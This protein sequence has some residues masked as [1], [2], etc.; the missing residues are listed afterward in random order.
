[1]VGHEGTSGTP[2]LYNGRDGVMTDANGLYYMRARYYDPE[3]R[4]FT[5][6]D[7]LV[8]RIEKVQ[9]LNRY[10]YVK[11]NPVLFVDPAG[12][13]AGWAEMGP[14]PYGHW[15]LT[16]KYGTTIGRAL[17]L[18]IGVVKDERNDDRYFYV[19]PGASAGL[20]ISPYKTQSQQPFC[21]GMSIN[22]SAAHVLGGAVSNPLA[23]KWNPSWDI[24]L[25][26]PGASA[27]A[28]YGFRLPSEM[29]IRVLTGRPQDLSQ[30][31]IDY[32]L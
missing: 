26:A 4:R 20:P 12:L 21:R 27:T 30:N 2:F 6:K 5:S 31:L 3:I 23:L 14:D 15:G 19:G 18:D 28:T 25:A 13:D 8:G 1:M 16:H 9:S 29:F 32:M 11:A 17:V 10:A 22:V 7:V 24:G